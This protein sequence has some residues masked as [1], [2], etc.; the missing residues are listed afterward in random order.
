MHRGGAS[1][2][3]S[4]AFTRSTTVRRICSLGSGLTGKMSLA[5]GPALTHAVVEPQDVG[6][7]LAFSSMVGG[8]AAR[9]GRPACGR[10]GRRG[11]LGL[12]SRSSSSLAD[13]LEL[14]LGFGP[15]LKGGW[16][17][18]P[19]RPSPSPSSCAFR[20]FS[21][22]SFWAMTVPPADSRPRRLEEASPW[23]ASERATILRP[24]PPRRAA[25]RR[26]GRA[27]RVEVARSR[28]RRSGSSACRAAGRACSRS[29]SAAWIEASPRT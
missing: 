26:S 22:F 10:P 14:L 27:D 25:P 5:S 24:S 4:T 11:R 13:G 3:H 1:L 18:S 15:G 17:A 21:S 2:S 12:E 23:D 16:M 6:E 20:V 28:P 29:S 7:R 8:S 9:R 19:R